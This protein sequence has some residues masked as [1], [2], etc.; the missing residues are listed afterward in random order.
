MCKVKRARSTLRLEF[1]FERGSLLSF[2]LARA[3]ETLNVV[4]LFN[5]IVKLLFSRKLN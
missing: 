3:I 5:Q 2:E 4:P 1:V